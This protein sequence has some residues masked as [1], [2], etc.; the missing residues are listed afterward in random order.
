MWPSLL[1]ISM[2]YVSFIASSYVYQMEQL[3]KSTIYQQVSIFTKYTPYNDK[4]DILAAL[5]PDVKAAFMRR[6]A[7]FEEQ[8]KR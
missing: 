7:N 8:A 4:L 1:F 2:V 3:L 6:Q 5:L